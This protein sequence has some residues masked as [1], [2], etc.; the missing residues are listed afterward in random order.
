M[1]HLLDL[2]VLINLVKSTNSGAP[3]DIILTSLP[4]VTQRP[5]GPNILT[6]VS[7]PVMFHAH[8]KQ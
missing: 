5:L 1:S 6:P 8:T 4:P 3:R 7:Y 2:I